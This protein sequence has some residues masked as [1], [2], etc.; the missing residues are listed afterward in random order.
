MEVEQA[1]NKEAF[2]AQ[3][4]VLAEHGYDLVIDA[5]HAAIADAV[6]PP[7]EDAAGVGGDSFGHGL[8]LISGGGC[9]KLPA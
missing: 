1:E 2:V 4:I 3:A 6:V 8:Q 9:S 7:V 5:F